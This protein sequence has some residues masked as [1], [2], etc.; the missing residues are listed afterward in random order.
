LRQEQA[1]TV[2]RIGRLLQRRDRLLKASLARDHIR[3]RGALREMRV[4]LRS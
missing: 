3:A 2:Q 4:E 1:G